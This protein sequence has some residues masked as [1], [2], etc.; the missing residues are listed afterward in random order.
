MIVVEHVTVLQEGRVGGYKMAYLM[1]FGDA[2]R[3]RQWMKVGGISTRFSNFQSNQT[4]T[5]Q[6]YS[7]IL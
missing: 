7:C 3:G 6:V 2:F 1:F 5:I 4:S